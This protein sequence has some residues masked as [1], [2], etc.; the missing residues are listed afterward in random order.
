M[1]LS[2]AEYELTGSAITVLFGKIKT[3]TLVSF[4]TSQDFLPHSTKV[5]DFIHLVRM[6]TSQLR[7]P[8]QLTR[9]P[10]LHYEQP[11]MFSKVGRW[12]GVKNYGFTGFVVYRPL[13]V[14]ADSGIDKLSGILRPF[15]SFCYF[16][17][18]IKKQEV[19]GPDTET[20]IKCLDFRER[21]MWG[22]GM[23]TASLPLISCGF[24]V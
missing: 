16:Q 13:V 17:S 23:K 10:H 5:N 24:Y 2:I 6:A 15:K 3:S 1:G 20:A 7:E 12:V 14:S 18:K 22:S 19:V 4:L 9:P 11:N 8:F 21:W